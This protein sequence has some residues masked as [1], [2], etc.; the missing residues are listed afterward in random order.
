MQGALDKQSPL[1]GV[2]WRVSRSDWLRARARDG[3]LAV[4]HGG[5]YTTTLG[6]WH[7]GYHG[8]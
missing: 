3:E 1:S 7:S 4:V 6:R 2:V 8:F 5:I